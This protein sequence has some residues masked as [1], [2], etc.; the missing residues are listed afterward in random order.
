[1]TEREYAISILEQGIDQMQGFLEALKT[2]DGQVDCDNELRQT[3]EYTTF[4]LEVT[5]YHDWGD[6]A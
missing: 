2:T 3:P 1:M 5:T 4:R 6:D